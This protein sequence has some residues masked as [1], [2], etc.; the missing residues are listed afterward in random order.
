M[1]SIRSL[2]LV[3]C[4]GSKILILTTGCANI[5]PPTGGPKDSIPPVLITVIP[6][7]STL[8]FKSTRIV[9]N[10]DEFL[11]LKDIRT[12]L[13]VS[14]FPKINPI[15]NSKLRTITI[16]LKDTLKPFT[17]YTFDF[18]KSI[19]D[20]NE[21]NIL[22]NFRYIFSTGSY[23]DS[24]ELRGRVLL[25]ATG[26]PDSTLI[27][28]LHKNTDDSAVAN[29]RP[30]YITRLDSSG[31]F[32]FRNLAP[33]TY[34]L[35][36]LKDESGTYR[37]TSKSQIFAFADTEILVLKNNPQVTLYAYSDT[38][39]SIQK[40]KT[41]TVAPKPKKQD[42]T[43]NRLILAINAPDGQFDLLDTFHLQSQIPLKY[44]DSSK[45]RFTDENF[46]DIPNAR[47]KEDSDHQKITLIYKWPG[48]TK[49]HIIAQKEFAEDTLDRKLLKIDTL[50]F[51]TKR[52]SEYGTLILHFKN[53]DPLKNPVL[54][55]VQKD[56]L[57][58]VLIINSSNYTYKLFPPGEYELRVLFDENKN[59]VWDPGDFFGKHKQPE[60]VKVLSRKLMNVKANWDNENDI[61]L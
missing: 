45:I 19:R 43:N 29:E 32:H 6:P 50:T 36:A 49:F 52:E 1:K 15:V 10:F 31:N 58:K 11:E 35:Y 26:K 4:V 12:E 28:M 60:K 40:K 8:N 42:N 34:A 53:Y 3:L 9:F 55:F 54:Q 48:D 51:R 56:Q 24:M 13:I 21:G 30:R 33:G 18:G 22:R 17:T 23:L 7:E 47:F 61:Q 59:G 38:S 25:A 57:K 37:Y 39:G 20:I 2:L 41:A 14:P 5:I 27:V 44:F 16:L 46:K